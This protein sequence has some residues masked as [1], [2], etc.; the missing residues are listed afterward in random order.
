MKPPVV[1]FKVTQGFGENIEYYKKIGLQNGHNGLDILTYHGQPV[2]A[3]HDGVATYQED[4]NGGCQVIIVGYPYRTIYLHLCDPK[5][6]PEFK[7]PIDNFRQNEV[8]AGDLIGYSDSTGFSTG[9]HLHFGLKLVNE[10]GEVL[11]ANNGFHGAID[12][13]PYFGSTFLFTKNLGL[14]SMGKEVLEL[15]K[16]LIS[17]GLGSFTP[18][19]F[20][21][22]KTKEAVVMYQLKHGIKPITGYVGPLTRAK[23]NA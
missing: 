5:K 13:M 19:G 23:L 8:R 22:K 12:P 15:Q 20:F 4:E 21:G 7:S 17:E 18:T 14:Y 2:Y 11:N 6:E 1:P 16:R 9:T 3:A 10:R